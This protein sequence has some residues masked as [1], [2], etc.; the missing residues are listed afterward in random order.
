MERLKELY[1]T[2]REVIVYLIVGV[3]TT[4]VNW[5][6]YFI[7]TKTFL[8]PKNDLQ[9]QIAVL[10]AWIVSVAFAYVTN[11][12]YVFLSKDPKILKEMSKFF[13]SRLTTYFLEVFIMWLTVSVMG[14]NDLIA[15]IGANVLVIIANYVFSK[16]LV[17]TKKEKA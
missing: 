6:V 13:V 11:R 14:I 17:F 3:L 7:C 9:L 5:V 10:I 16:L 4:L 15:K 8:D 12:K 2:Y 1:K